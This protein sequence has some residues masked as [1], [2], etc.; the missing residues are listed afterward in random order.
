MHAD[1][2]VRE[3]ALSFQ[4]LV[5]SDDRCIARRDAPILRKD[6][7]AYGR[8]SFSRRDATTHD[9][10]ALFAAVELSAPARARRASLV[11]RATRK[12]KIVRD[13]RKQQKNVRPDGARGEKSRMSRADMIRRCEERASLRRPICA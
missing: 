8:P 12:K 3:R 4:L 13:R 9:G 5:F 1:V 10:A 2:N 7:D 6:R 11:A